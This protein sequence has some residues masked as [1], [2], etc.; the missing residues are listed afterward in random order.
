MLSLA[1]RSFAAH[2]SKHPAD[3]LHREPERS[4]NAVI[5]EPLVEHAVR[6]R[7]RFVDSLRSVL[8]RSDGVGLGAQAATRRSVFARCATICATCE[9]VS[10]ERPDSSRSGSITRFRI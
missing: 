8:L 3:L 10:S 9:S 2:A 5:A 6:G 4:C 7:A 1:Q